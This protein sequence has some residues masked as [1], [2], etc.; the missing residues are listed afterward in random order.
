MFQIIYSEPNNYVVICILPFFCS[1]QV[2]D[3]VR[4]SATE[5]VENDFAS[6]DVSASDEQQLNGSLSSPSSVVATE[7]LPD[8]PNKED[9]LYS[10]GGADETTRCRGA[11]KLTPSAE[12]TEAGEVSSGET[13]STAAADSSV[14]TEASA[15][16]ASA[17][18]P[19]SAGIATDG[20][21]A[22]DQLTSFSGEEK[23][24]LSATLQTTTTTTA[25]TPSEAEQSEH[26]DYHLLTSSLVETATAAASGG[27][28]TTTS[29]SDYF[30]RQQPDR[31]ETAA[32]PGGAAEQLEDSEKS[33]AA[34]EVTPPQLEDHGERAAAAE[35]SK[36]ATSQLEDS[37]AAV[38]LEAVASGTA[39]AAAAGA[40][41]EAEGT[42][43][44]EEVGGAADNAAT[45]AEEEEL[46]KN[47]FPLID[48]F[49]H[50]PEI[51]NDQT[52]RV[53]VDEHS[54]TEKESQD[55]ELAA[56]VAYDLVETAAVE[57]PNL[58]GSGNTERAS[59]TDESS[60]HLDC[61]VPTTV[62][63]S[64]EN[65]DPSEEMGNKPNK[66]GAGGEGGG[67]SSSN[68]RLN[69]SRDH[70]AVEPSPKRGKF[71][72]GKAPAPGKPGGKQQVCQ[73]CTLSELSS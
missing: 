9:Q 44:L 70:L 10:T 49:S 43:Q 45:S 58:E 3:H 39:A 48:G 33:A 51:T 57:P 35:E 63:S 69:K 61:Q 22:A 67:V 73:V 16:N 7:C 52:C 29:K 40:R 71:G 53:S 17:E 24:L 26:H 47:C 18:A 65:E 36:G 37:V 2:N 15:S 32:A 34:E 4:S 20:S 68:S 54:E 60:L 8:S 28:D 19:T 21:S 27:G 30:F 50:P 42:L 13:T 64:L 12:A 41:K 11:V 1:F 14:P 66:G 25:T 6:D 56:A 5:S 72:K 23:P 31:A 62:V 59:S 46:C 38:E 55:F